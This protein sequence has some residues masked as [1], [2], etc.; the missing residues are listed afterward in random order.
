VNAKSFKNELERARSRPDVDELLAALSAQFR[1]HQDGCPG[2]GYYGD[3]ELYFDHSDKDRSLALV[4]LAMANFDD[5]GFL[6]MVA[7]GPLEDIFFAE[8]EVPEDIVV[9]IEDEARKT[10]RFRWMLSGVWTTSFKPEH[11]TR[12]ERAAAGAKLEDPLPPRPWA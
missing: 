4:V 7:A 3:L 12:V 11:A 10:P 1:W 5:P 8:Q 6:G 2:D 9:R